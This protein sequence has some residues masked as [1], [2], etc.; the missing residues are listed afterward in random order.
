MLEYGLFTGPRVIVA[1]DVLMFLIAVF[2]LLFETLQQK[3]NNRTNTKF[4]KEIFK[5]LSNE[6]TKN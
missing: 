1:P 5:S 3:I 4:N 6:Q 2:G